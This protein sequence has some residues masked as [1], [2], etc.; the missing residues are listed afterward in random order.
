[1]EGRP[2]PPVVGLHCNGCRSERRLLLFAANRPPLRSS[3]RVPRRGRTGVVGDDASLD[4]GRNFAPGRQEVP[5]GA[6]GAGL[7]C[8]GW[9]VSPENDS[10]CR[11]SARRFEGGPNVRRRQAWHLALTQCGALEPRSS[12]PRGAV[13][14]YRR[15][16]SRL[17][18]TGETSTAAPKGA[19][20]IE[21]SPVSPKGDEAAAPQDV[22]I[23]ETRTLVAAAALTPTHDLGGSRAQ[24]TRALRSACHRSE[25]GSPPPHSQVSRRLDFEMPS[26]APVRFTTRGG[27]WD[28]PLCDPSRDRR[29]GSICSPFP[30]RSCPLSK[31]LAAPRFGCLPDGCAGTSVEGDLPDPVPE[32]AGLLGCA[33]SLAGWQHRGPPEGTGLRETRVEPSRPCRP[34]RHE[35]ERAASAARRSPARGG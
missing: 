12:R 35:G 34:T 32:G 10:P 9:Q 25:S 28:R 19:D 11:T 30:V 31:R 20:T 14:P 24:G 4:S 2:G 6:Q 22:R 15:S 21:V 18:T 16:M 26:R 1:M 33:P 7:R 13:E 8:A 27:H 29:R 17:R 23:P 5:R 3:A